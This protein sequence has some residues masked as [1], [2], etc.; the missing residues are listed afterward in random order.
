MI[1][2]KEEMIQRVKDCGQEVIDHAENIVNDYK[3]GP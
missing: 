2:N 3:Y 1:C